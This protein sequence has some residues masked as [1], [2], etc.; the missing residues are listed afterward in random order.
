MCDDIKEVRVTGLDAE[1]EK[2][3]D[4]WLEEEE[5]EEEGNDG[6]QVKQVRIT[7]HDEKD[8]D[9]REE[10]PPRKRKLTWTLPPAWQDSQKQWVLL[11]ERGRSNPGIWRRMQQEV[12]RKLSSYKRQDMLK[13]RFRADK[14]IRLS[15]VWEDLDASQLVCYYCCRPIFVLYD[16]VLDDMQWTLD[17]IDNTEGHNGDNVHIACLNCNLQRR[18]RNDDDFLFTQQLVIVIEKD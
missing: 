4:T 5:K 11:M 15:Q 2:D 9:A 17:R 10:K 18:R 7:V 12:Q 1:E 13:D 8:A 14:F 3:V 16:E 6:D